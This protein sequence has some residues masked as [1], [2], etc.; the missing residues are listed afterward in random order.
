MCFSDFRK[1]Y[2]ILQYGLSENSILIGWQVCIKTVQVSLIV[3]LMRR[4][5]WC[6][7]THTEWAREI[8]DHTHS[9]IQDHGHLLSAMLATFKIIALILNC[10][11]ISFI[12]GELIAVFEVTKL[13]VLL[14]AE[15]DAQMQVIHKHNIHLSL[16]LTVDN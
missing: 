11:I 13:T 5:Y 12:D 10:Y 2:I 3:I 14:F 9:N 7:Q 8:A 6:M 15:R 16:S 1:N 4:F